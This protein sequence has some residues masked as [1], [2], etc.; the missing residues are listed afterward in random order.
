VAILLKS[1]SINP[2]EPPGLAQ[3]CTEIALPFTQGL[4]TRFR[5]AESEML[6]TALVGSTLQTDSTFVIYSLFDFAERRI[7]IS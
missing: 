7:A 3:T 5:K 4:H 6:W 1:E 2:L